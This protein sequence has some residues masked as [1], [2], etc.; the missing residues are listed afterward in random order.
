MAELKKTLSYPVV[1]LITVNSIMG[2]GIFFLPAVGAGIAGPA[3]IISWLIMAVLSM[4]V[5]L[6]FAELV[7]MYPKAGGVY[8][9]T[10]QAF[11]PFISFIVG[12]MTMIAGNVT[13]A[14]LIVG[15]VQYLSPE[16]S[17]ILKIIISIGFIL[18]F[19]YM[20][21]RGMQTSAV[22]LVTFGIIT[23]TTLFALIVPGVISFSTAN[24]DPFFV[25]E[26]SLI[27][28]AIFFIA[29]TFFGWETTTFLAEETKDAE[30]VMP[31]A[32]WVGTLIIGIIVML[33]VITSLSTIH[34]S[35]FG[36]SAA[37]LSD[38]AM[39]HYG[40]GVSTAIALLVY[41]SI[42]G[43]VAG[44]IVSAPR[45]LM[46]LAEDKL[47]IPHLADIHPEY[48]TP[49]KSILFQ[50]VLTS[51]L[52]IIGAGSYETL[53]HLLLPVVLLLYSMVIISFIV[54]R[55]TKKDQPRPFKVWFGVPMGF[56]LIGFLLSLIISWLILDPSAIH[57]LELVLGFGLIGVPVFFLLTFY[58]N[59]SA[60]IKFHESSAHLSLLLEGFILPKKIRKEIV[61]TLP[62]LRGKKILDFGS[63]VGTLTKHLMKHVGTE[64]HIVATDM[65]KRNLR[66][67]ENRLK[68]KQ[69]MNF[70]IL[71][72]PR[73]LNRAHP[74]LPFVDVVV[75]VGM[76]SYIQDLKKVLEELNRLLPEGGSVCF[77]EFIDYFWLFPNA[78]WLKDEERLL[79]IFQESGFRVQLVKVKGFF[80]KYLMVYGQKTRHREEVYI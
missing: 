79:E 57:T 27:F 51:I 48:N 7:G 49:Y 63:G 9:Y 59:P 32:L 23:L 6:I 35:E 10:K 20:A 52:V 4:G 78:G 26:M 2:T 36:M 17:N 65:S 62:E 15:A 31:K 8:E 67:L 39:V 41:M 42:I 54:M 13:I 53:L 24:L 12:W 72:D 18:V 76:I 43:S 16:M 19:N 1:L 50:T 74:E 21:Y 60:I 38:L 70:S 47:F 80:W 77:V 71:H 25:T 64:G 22:M 45:L 33:F 3:S 11:G 29:E 56:I 69:H 68:K 61:L 40:E 44:W 5:S 55:F 46:S 66:I 37:P 14:M 30:H 34:Y 28:L 73:Q 75:S 58:Y